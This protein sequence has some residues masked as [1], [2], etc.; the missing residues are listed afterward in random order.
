ME[1]PDDELEEIEPLQLDIRE[2]KPEK[3]LQPLLVAGSDEKPGFALAAE[4][5]ASAG[6]E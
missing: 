2:L 5:D 4:A 3:W 1:H 6:A